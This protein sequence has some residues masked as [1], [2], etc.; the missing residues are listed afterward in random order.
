MSEYSGNS[1]PPSNAISAGTTTLWEGT[2]ARATAIAAPDSATKKITVRRE[3]LS[4]SRPIGH[5]NA[6]APIMGAARKM[7]VRSSDRPIVVAY[8]APN[9]STMPTDEPP[10]NEPTTPVGMIRISSRTVILSVASTDGALDVA[11]V[12]GTNDIDTSTDETTK[13]WKPFGS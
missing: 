12:I 10:M 1:V 3:T 6:I 13:S 4:D 7:A 8:T 2:R 9:P 5:C 11:S